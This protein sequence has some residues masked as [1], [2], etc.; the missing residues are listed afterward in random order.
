MREKGVAKRYALAF[1]ESAQAKGVLEAVG[2]EL[3]AFAHVYEENPELR[4]TLMNPAIPK[5]SKKKIVV[6]VLKTMNLSENCR[7]AVALLL[8]KGRVDFVTDVSDRFNEIM[9]ER[10]GRVKVKITSA[11]TLGGADLKKLE[12]TFAALTKKTVK[13]ETRTDSSLIAG[14]VAR[15]GSRVYDGSLSN[16]LRLMKIK[17][18]GEA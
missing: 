3:S 15:I 13:L 1:V 12:S 4:K 11:Q 9:D 7:R 18:G 8:E 6:S 10:L 2:G 16:Q 5:M 14:I 17:L